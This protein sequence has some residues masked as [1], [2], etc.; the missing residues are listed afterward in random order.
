MWSYVQK[1]NLSHVNR[2][3]DF[4]IRQKKPKCCL[5]IYVWQLKSL[6]FAIFC[7][8]SQWTAGLEEPQHRQ[9]SSPSL[10]SRSWK[11]LL[12]NNELNLSSASGGD[13]GAALSLAQAF[14][15]RMR[16][17]AHT[18]THSHNPARCHSSLPQVVLWEMHHWLA[19]GEEKNREGSKVG[20]R[21]R[22][23]MVSTW[24]RDVWRKQGRGWEV[25][26]CVGV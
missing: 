14:V 8:G 9:S 16:M 10:S 6:S 26:V 21:R 23:V 20:R 19:V 15:A 25:T 11:P 5:S 24:R 17:L 4:T 7:V 18:S 3:P 13:L 2:E 12:L 1:C 22:I